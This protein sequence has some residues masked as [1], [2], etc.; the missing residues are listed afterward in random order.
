MFGTAKRK[1]YHWAIDTILNN[2]YQIQTQTDP[3]FSGILAYWDLTDQ[4]WCVRP[5]MSE[6]EAALVIAGAYYCG[7]LGT[8][9]FE[10][11]AILLSRI[12]SVGQRAVSKGTLSPELWNN[13][14]ILLNKRHNQFGI[15]EIALP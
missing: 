4:L 14:L 10:E 6:D 7:L 1:K 15:P 8:G 11:A 2:E 9:R 12:I 5:K 3:N 13:N